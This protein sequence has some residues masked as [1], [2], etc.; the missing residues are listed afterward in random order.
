M[1]QVDLSRKL[2]G[3]NDRLGKAL[4]WLSLAMVGVT[5]LVVVLRY[6]F[7]IGSAWLQDLVIYLHSAMFLGAAGYTLLKDG[8]VRVDIF[9]RGLSVRARNWVN[10]L[11]GL[12]LLFPTIGVIAWQSWPYVADSWTVL[13]G[14]QDAGLPVVFLLKTMILLYCAVLG[15]QGLSLMLSSWSQLRGL[16]DE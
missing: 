16:R 10:L 8:H 13:E 11:G 15:L 9:Y 5:F 6:V 14:S 4:S 12:L 3:L 1:S 2:D 7:S